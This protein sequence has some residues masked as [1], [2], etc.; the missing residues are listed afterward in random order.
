MESLTLVRQ[1]NVAGRFAEALKA[2]ERAG[3]DADKS[4]ISKPYLPEEFLEIL[5]NAV[6]ANPE[7]M[8]DRI[9]DILSNR[10]IR[11]N[12]SRASVD[13]IRESYG[14]DQARQIFW[15]NFNRV[16]LN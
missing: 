3:V 5:A 12:F 7:E 11:E 2:L 1:L 8:A 16:F 13:I 14:I 15:E 4:F 10:R 6:S 9:A